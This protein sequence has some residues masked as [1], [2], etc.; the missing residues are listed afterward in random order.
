MDNRVFTHTILLS[1]GAMGYV[2]CVNGNLFVAY[3]ATYVPLTHEEKT[4]AILS[5]QTRLSAA[6]ALLKLAR[7]S[8][9]CSA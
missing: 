7:C 8:P 6:L 4:E 2:A 3:S 5:M 1:T 9:C